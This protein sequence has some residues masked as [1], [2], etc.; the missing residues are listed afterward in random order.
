MGTRSK[1]ATGST[2]CDDGDCSFS[3]DLGLTMFNLTP[4]KSMPYGPFSVSPHKYLLNVCTK[5]SQ[6]AQQ[7]NSS[8]SMCRDERGQLIDSY[9][10]QILEAG[11]GVNLGTRIGYAPYRDPNGTTPG[12]IVTYTGGTFACKGAQISL[13][14]N[15][16]GRERATNISFVCDPNAGTGA[17]VPCA[18]LSTSIFS[19]FGTNGV[20]PR[21]CEYCFVW[22]SIYGCPVCGERDRQIVYVFLF[23]IRFFME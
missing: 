14:E 10:C 18:P 11:V 4:L 20:E 16:P 7:S 9:A 12:V 2:D 3:P 15:S 13:F 21:P 1:N 6:F 8:V 17:P 19:F 23:S 22:R 5:N